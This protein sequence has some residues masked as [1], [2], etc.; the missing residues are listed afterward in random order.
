MAAPHSWR[1][2][3]F[4]VVA[5]AFAGFTGFTLVTPFFPLYI[6]QLGVSDVGEIAL[7]AGLSLGV[8]PAVT[9]ALSPF[10]GRLADRF[11]RKLMVMRSLVSFVII[12]TLTAYVTAAW[13]IFALRAIQGLFAGYG[14]LTLA[15]AAESAPREKMASAIG[16]V[17]TA[18][19]LGPA[20][21]P[22]IGGIVAEVVGLRR[23]F[24]VTAGFYALALVLVA[25]LYRD[26]ERGG[27]GEQATAER[28]SFR[29]LL[30]FPNFAMMMVAIFG[31]TFVDRSFGPMLPLYVASVGIAADR[32]ALYS[33]LLFSAAAVGG[34]AGNQSCG[35]LLR[36]SSP[37]TVIGAAAFVS[38]AS[39]AV[40]LA[41][42]QMW[43]LAV[44]FIV[45]GLGIGAATT[46]AYTAGGRVI[47]AAVHGT[48]FGL[49]TGAGLA[50]LALSPVV[51]GLLTTSGFAVVF[52]LDV[53][54]L[55]ALGV[56]VRRSNGRTR[57][58]DSIEGGPGMM[59]QG[60]TDPRA[61]S[62]RA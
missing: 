24:F 13:Q 31:I 62:T 42:S 11:G 15:M 47:P 53:L 38:A 23:A 26:P 35:W 16:G 49:L 51:S 48:G 19:R 14:G 39:L 1:R 41:T 57:S 21:G 28:I 55:V 60:A 43:A 29:T 46:A 50:G 22:V 10:W 18:Q 6:R 58:G 20:L 32:V 45:F 17:H 8:T 61:D 5:A 30:G 52:V 12:M 7:W 27:R 54:V 40:F 33:G 59:E 34:A 3:Q 4:A 56:V 25:V 44:V 2:N 36:R 37:L 9:A